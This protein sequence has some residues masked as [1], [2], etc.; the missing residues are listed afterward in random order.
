MERNEQSWHNGSLMM[1]SKINPPCAQATKFLS[2]HASDSLASLMGGRRLKPSGD[3]AV[4]RSLCRRGT[5]SCSGIPL[6]NVSDPGHGCSDTCSGG[7]PGGEHPKQ[8]PFPFCMPNQEGCRKEPKN[9]FPPQKNLWID[10][11]SDDFEK[12]WVGNGQ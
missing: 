11:K 5:G 6:T 7:E 9:D 12:R 4:T 8:T 10:R 3:A 2:K 1:F